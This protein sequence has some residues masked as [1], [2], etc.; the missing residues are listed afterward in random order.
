MK[1]F[2]QVLYILLIMLAGGCEK[3][4][5]APDNPICGLPTRVLM[6]KGCGSGNPDFTENTL[7]AANYGLSVLDGIELDIQMS[8]EGTLWL[9]HNNEVLDCEG[10]IIG[11][12]QQMTDEEIMAYAECNDTIRYNTLESVFELMATTYPESFISL[13]IKGQYC[14]ITNTREM[15]EQMAK[16][17]LNLVEKYKMENK[18]L[19]ESSSIEFMSE[20]ED[21]NSVGQCVITVS[22]DVDEGLANAEVT[23]SR[24]ISLKYGIEEFNADVVSLIHNKGYGI[25][26]WY[27][28]EPED[29]AKAWNAHPDFIQTDNADF[30]KYIPANK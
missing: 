7:A 27:I 10:N 4:I 22:G 16:S 5:Y 18:V 25:M 1:Y 30:K 12:F 6:H 19:V 23:N 9:D 28:N 8:K 11:C 26:V 24:G 13:D 15:M 21:Q 17:V 29:I 2:N 20:F 14:E 3:I